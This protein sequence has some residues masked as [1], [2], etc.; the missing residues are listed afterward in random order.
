M[1]VP[2]HTGDNPRR[3]ATV[4][5]LVSLVSLV[6]IRPVRSYQLTAVN[7][8][9]KV[10]F[11]RINAEPPFGQQ[12]IAE[13]DSRTL[14][15]VGYVENLGDHLETVCNVQWCADDPGVIAEGRAQHLPE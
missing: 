1:C 4:G 6:A 11:F 3:D 8:G 2:G 13:D 14:E 15:A 7:V 9:M 12:Q 10:E 5:N